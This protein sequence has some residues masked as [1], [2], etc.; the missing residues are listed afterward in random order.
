MI[1][2]VSEIELNLKRDSIVE[3]LIY[4]EGSGGA[5]RLSKK[6]NPVVSLTFS[7]CLASLTFL[8]LSFSM[9]R[10]SKLSSSMFMSN[11]LAVSAKSL[12]LSSKSPW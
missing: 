11:K 1:S 5:L 8:S 4:F 3:P 10:F 2:S 9:D 7:A 6:F 12:E